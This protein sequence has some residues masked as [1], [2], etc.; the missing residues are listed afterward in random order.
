[1]NQINRTDEWSQQVWKYCFSGNIREAYQLLASKQNL[2][3]EWL[4]LREDLFERF[5]AERPSLPNPPISNKLEPFLNCYYLYLI[6]VL[7]QKIERKQ[8]EEE[9]SDNLSILLKKPG[10]SME[11]LEAELK[12]V[13][14]KESYHFLGGK[15]EPFY[16]PYIWAAN[17]ERE[18]EVEIPLGK[19]RLKVNFMHGF[20]M[21]GWLDFATC[22][23]RGAGGWAKEEGLYCVYDVYKDIL[24]SS[25]FQVSYLKHEA[26]HAD[27][28]KRFPHIKS[29]ELE[30]R[31]KLVELIYEETSRILY[32]LVRDADPNPDFPHNYS[33]YLIIQD[34]EKQAGFRFSTQPNFTN[35]L[36]DKV[37]NAAA[38]AFLEHTAS[39]EKRF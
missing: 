14:E 22:G 17:E 23:R 38:K 33:S 31:A 16:G 12:V 8:A 7:L 2:S 27:D 11:Q 30:Y 1:M 13:F 5:F 9:L 26:Q 32:Q 29:Y 39:L 35:D 10:S 34:L 24:D 3:K 6:Q 28:F 19:Q 21:K 37:R 36:I 20:I 18:Y 25:K 15:T 4:K